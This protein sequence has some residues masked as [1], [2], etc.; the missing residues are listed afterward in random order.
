MLLLKRRILPLFRVLLSIPSRD[1]FAFSSEDIEVI[2]YGVH[3]LLLDGLLY[4]QGLRDHSELLVR[5]DDA[6]LIVVLDVG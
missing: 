4:L 1:A 5:Q 2:F 6:S 3:L